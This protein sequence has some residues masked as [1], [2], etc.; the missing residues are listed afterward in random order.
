MMQKCAPTLAAQYYKCTAGGTL[1]KKS[2]T[3]FLYNHLFNQITMRELG[4]KYILAIDFVS[5]CIGTYGIIKV[6]NLQLPAHLEAGGPWQFLTNLS[7]AYSLVVFI[8]GFLAH[9]IKC[10]RLYAVKNYLH[11]IALALE[12]IVAGIYWPLRLFFL[13]LLA[14]DPSKFNLPLRV[15][16]SIHLMPVVS[17][18]IDYL[19]FMPKW[20][21]SAV[22]AFF[23]CF[24]L[25][26]GYWF[27]LKSLVDFD[28]GGEYPYVF[29]NVE[30]ERLRMTIFSTV[31]IVAF[32][33]FLVMRALYDRLLTAAKEEEREK[34]EI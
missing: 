9:L 5:V 22:G 21:L 2:P 28:N 30:N 17:L 15:D 10:K 12:T 6:T 16:L 7:L 24:I 4:N 14:K 26:T 13:H 11:P 18:L 20:T 31:G 34:K 25:T 32:V 3:F 19:V 29:L 8:V 33:Q 27:L 23:N 1:T